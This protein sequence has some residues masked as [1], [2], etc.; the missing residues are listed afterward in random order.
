MVVQSGNGGGVVG[1]GGDG[2]VGRLS[3]LR[4]GG[5]VVVVLVVVIGR[6]R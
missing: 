2:M 5:G 3:E 6:E 1:R 4:D